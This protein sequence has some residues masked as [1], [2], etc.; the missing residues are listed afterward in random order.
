[1]TFLTG[2]LEPGKD[3]VGDYTRMLAAACTRLGVA[4]QIVAVAD[5]HIAHASTDR[6]ASDGESGMEIVRL[7]DRLSWPSRLD[8]A[9]RVMKAFR[10]QWVSAQFVPFS[11]HRWGIAS[12]LVRA[13]PRLAGQA[14]LH[15][16]LHEIWVGAEGSWR[17]RLMSEAQRRCVLRLCRYPG[18]LVH[19]SNAAYQHIL[20]THGIGARVLPLFGNIPIASGGAWPWLAPELAAAGCDAGDRRSAWWI[21]VLFGTLHP[22]WPPEP[23]FGRLQQAARDAG[24]RVAVI[25][26]GRLGSGEALWNVLS[27]RYAESFVMLRIGEQTDGRV[28]EVMNAADFGIAT[29]PYALLEKSGTAVAMFEHGLPVIV[30]REEGPAVR[31]VAENRTVI[32]LDARF[33]T[34]LAEA[35]RADPQSRLESVA[36]AFIGDLQAACPGDGKAADSVPVVA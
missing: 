18:T 34:R 5:R 3:G 16:M 27:S 31:G 29:S 8:T 25:S 14:R 30:N 26:V 7:P 28:S 36:T 1:V 10:P 35:R 6:I 22:N 23:L 13:L 32:R 20:E 24:K 9:D 15:V 2:S 33:A 12:T 19:T 4:C 11:F 17:R 21:C